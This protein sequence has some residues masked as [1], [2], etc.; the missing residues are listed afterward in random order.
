MQ[1][2]PKLNKQ[3]VCFK[4]Q[5]NKNPQGYFFF[6]FMFLERGVFKLTGGL[7]HCLS[8]E[9]CFAKHL[10]AELG[11]HGLLSQNRGTNWSG[12]SVENVI[13]LSFKLSLPKKN[14]IA[15]CTIASSVTP[16]FLYLLNTC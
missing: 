4:D 5:I 2:H 16:H 10:F 6:G 7:L 14:P 8:S 12:T 1:L 9:H 3:M 11:G 15:T 13:R